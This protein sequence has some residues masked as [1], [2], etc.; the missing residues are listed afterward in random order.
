MKWHR[1]PSP[2]PRARLLGILLMGLLAGAINGLLGAGGGI[3]IVYVLS[4]TLRASSPDPRDLYA[5]ALCIMLPISAF[6]CLR[7]SLAGHLS[8]ESF[9]VYILP[10]VLGGF[11]GGFLLGKLKATVVKKLF[12][13]LVIYS[14]IVL[15]IR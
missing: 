12:A 4:I 15:I 8:T 14:G 6:S 10:A 2:L 5:N 11:V 7:Y 1:L 9:S 3:L 13:A